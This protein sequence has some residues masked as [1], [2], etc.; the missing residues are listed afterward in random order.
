MESFLRSKSVRFEQ[1]DVARTY[2]ILDAASG[3]L[4]AYFS[5]SF[6]EISLEHSKISRTQVKR[7]DG[8]S[9]NADCVRA[10]LIGQIGKNFTLSQNN[11]SL[12]LI[13]D[14]VYGVI[15]EARA[16]IG[17]RAVILECEKNDKLIALYQANHFDIL[18][19]SDEESLVTMYT[20]I[21]D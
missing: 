11:I 2:L 7:L 19:D 16:L 21:S 15:Q 18:I 13:L 1:S 8:I 17:S 6:K 12:K 20:Y 9:K 10:Y 5:L 14:E 3:D 4:L